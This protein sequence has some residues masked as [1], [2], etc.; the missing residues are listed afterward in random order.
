MFSNFHA[1]SD[2]FPTMIQQLLPHLAGFSI[3]RVTIADDV[4]T[5]VAQSQTASAACPDCAGVSSRVH[6]RYIRHLADL[7][8]GR[9]AIRLILQVRRFFCTRWTCARKTFAEALP[10][11]TE[12]YARQTLQLKEA[13][14]QLGL[15]LGGEAGALARN[16][17]EA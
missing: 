12:R 14:I 16:S 3:E 17:I 15:A 7:P 10:G 4:I 5:I 1:F 11:I 6:S 13:L 9:R 2:N 8:W